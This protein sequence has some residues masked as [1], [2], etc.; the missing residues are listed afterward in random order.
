MTHPTTAAASLTVSS[1]LVGRE[2]GPLSHAVDARWLMAYAAGLGETEARYYDTLN[3]AGPAAH[4][5][6]PVCYE[7]PLAVALRAATISEEIARLS[8]HAVHDLTIHRPP[9]AGDTLSTT[10]RIAGI[11]RRPAGTLVVVYF[12][13]VD[14]DGRPVTT[15][16]Y[17]SVY[18]GVGVVGGD[19]HPAASMPD[20]DA[21]L[22][23][24]PAATARVDV[25]MQLAHLYTE[26]ARI[27]NPIHTDVA[28][29]KQAGLPAIILHGTA[30]LALAVSRLLSYLE[31]E[32]RQVT[33]VSCRFTGMV[34][35]PSTF[36]V[37][38]SAPFD[39]SDSV[40]SPSPPGQ[41]RISARRVVHFDAVTE[42]G[43]AVLSRGALYL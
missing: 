23:W 34:C 3:A 29:A 11:T 22:T 17:G 43:R 18:R 31:A 6:F 37:R 30:T 21:T 25:P 1:D 24:S 10:A 5:I 19:R 38:M 12:D 7:W 14:A 39:P 36:T 35:L 9:R 42:D 4:P 32:P 16:A 26:C 8:V 27:W 28:I 40:A 13:T 20:L 33:R 41:A 2:L 15:T